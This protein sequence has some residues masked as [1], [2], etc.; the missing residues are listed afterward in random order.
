MVSLFPRNHSD[1]VCPGSMLWAPSF[2]D[3]ACHSLL[4][5][6]IFP[7]ETRKVCCLHWP[8]EQ[9]LDCE[10][11]VEVAL[12]VTGAGL[13]ERGNARPKSNSPIP[14][15]FDVSTATRCAYALP[16]VYGLTWAVG[17]KTSTYKLRTSWAKESKQIRNETGDLVLRH[18]C[19]LPS[20]GLPSV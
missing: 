6:L 19:F 4:H 17:E 9:V 18:T 3:C 8:S 10:R 13:S 15:P 16:Q 7:S 20:S 14:P 12:T 1:S 2:S 5:G 11:D